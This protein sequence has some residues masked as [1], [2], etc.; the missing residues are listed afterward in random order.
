[1][2][3]FIKYGDLFYFNLSANVGAMQPNKT[4]DVELVRFGYKMRRANP[5]A[6]NK[7]QLNEL[8]DQMNAKGGYGPDLQ[9][10]IDEHQ[11]GLGGPRDGRISRAQLFSGD[12]LYDGKNVWIIEGLTNSM[13]VAAAANFPRID[14]H[15]DC[16]PELAK[17]VKRIF[18]DARS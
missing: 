11:S 4:D 3:D 14:L 15:D 10:V 16:G 18:L 5:K 6:A 9:A 1:M 12:G 2:V 17:A 8:T 7:P 13:R